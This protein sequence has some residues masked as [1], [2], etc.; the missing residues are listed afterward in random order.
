MTIGF[1]RP[2]VM[3]NDLVRDY[4]EVI[5]TFVYKIGLGSAQF[6]LATAM[7]LF[8]ALIG[9]TFVVASNAVAKRFGEQGIW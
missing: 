1:E 4:S 7:G 6:S 3:G 9:L 8:Q 2:F 5:S